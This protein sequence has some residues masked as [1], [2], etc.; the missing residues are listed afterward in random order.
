[1]AD[2]LNK[3]AV[4]IR[5]LINHRLKSVSATELRAEST[6]PHL[7]EDAI[8]AYIEG[9]LAEAECKPVL[10]H[11]AACG[12]CRRVSAQLVRLE[13]Q[14]DAEPVGE[15]TSAE[16][17]GRLESL[18]SR[19]GSIGA[20]NEDV[21]FAYQNPSEESSDESNASNADPNDKRGGS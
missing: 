12:L 19:L 11:L 16:D 18:L 1:M 15:S 10:A 20:S 2:R 13:N 9:R 4:A 6:E 14:I 8:A 7:D 17:S 5:D 3:K 21:V